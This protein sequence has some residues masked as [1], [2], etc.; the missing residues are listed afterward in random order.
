[1]GGSLGVGE[2]KDEKCRGLHWV[3]GPMEPSKLS[4][5]QTYF[6]RQT[7]ISFTPLHWKIGL[8]CRCESAGILDILTLIRKKKNLHNYTIRTLHLQDHDLYSELYATNFQYFGVAYILDDTFH[9]SDLFLIN[10]LYVYTCKIS[11]AHKIRIIFDSY[12]KVQ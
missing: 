12:T 9:F 3:V 2:Q 11:Q 7:E 4:N 5:S 10:N 8:M 6:S 1:M